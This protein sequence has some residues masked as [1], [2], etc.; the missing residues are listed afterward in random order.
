MKQTMT[1]DEI[2]FQI[3]IAQNVP[4]SLLGD[5]GRIGQIITK[6]LSDITNSMEKGIIEINVS[7]CK[8]SYSVE[9]TIEIKDHGM[10]M[11]EAELSDIKD[12][13]ENGSLRL[14]ESSDGNKIGLSII[15]M[16][17]RQMSGNIRVESVENEGT[18]YT[19]ILPQLCIK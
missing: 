3:N 8:R 4:D 14:L 10:G 9:L 1:N 19:I 15:V 11:N 6:L 18:S 13:I 2:D 16:L 5:E 17:V 12:Y 7:C